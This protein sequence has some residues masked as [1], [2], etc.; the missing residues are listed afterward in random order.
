MSSFAIKG[1]IAASTIYWSRE[2]KV[3]GSSTDTAKL[4]SQLSAHAD[5]S[6]KQLKAQIPIDVSTTK[7]IFSVLHCLLKILFTIFCR[8]HCCLRLAKLAFSS[9]II[10]TT[11][12]R[13]P[14]TLFIDFRVIW[15]NGPKKLRTP[16]IRH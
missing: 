9:S 2:Y 12:S 6:I 1:G 11:A 15:D 3:W 16:S 7:P 13:T 4:Y 5:P 8:C 14:F 10:T